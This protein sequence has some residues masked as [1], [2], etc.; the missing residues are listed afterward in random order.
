MDTNEYFT[1]K[2][3]KELGNYVY[4]LIDPRNGETFYVGK[5]TGNRVFH[6][7]NAEIKGESDKADDDTSRKM[8][9]IHAIRNAGLEVIHI[10]HRHKIDKE[11][12]FD[13]E[14]A[15]IDA[16]SGLTNIAGGHGS[17]YRGPMHAAQI[18]DKYQLPEITDDP[19]HKLVLININKLDKS[20]FDEI[21][22]QT[23]FSW[24]INVNRA[25]KADYILSV[26]RGVVVAAIRAEKWDKATKENFPDIPSDEPGRFAF[27]GTK[28]PDDIWETYVGKRGKRIV[29]ADMKHV[30]YPIRYWK[31]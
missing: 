31:I 7:V 3:C 4:R 28:A 1:A 24:R 12:V 2:V 15:V 26:V 19:K 20:G 5:G 9:R 27:K 11:A 10:I 29:N 6:H 16:F 22:K 30:Q 25:K 17:N 14:A 13:V 21:Y 18:I 8:D 23:R